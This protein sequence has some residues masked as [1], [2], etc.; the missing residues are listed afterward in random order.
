LEEQGSPVPSA[1]EPAPQADVPATSA[2]EQT[3]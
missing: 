1:A 3:A 2:G